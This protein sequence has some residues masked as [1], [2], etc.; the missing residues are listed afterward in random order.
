MKYSLLFLAVSAAMSKLSYAEEAQL[1]DV[2]ISGS[3]FNDYKVD[4]AKG[5]M[6]SHVSLLD[7]PQSVSNNKHYYR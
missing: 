3:Y 6:R 2:V 5:A 1:D 7:T 4:D